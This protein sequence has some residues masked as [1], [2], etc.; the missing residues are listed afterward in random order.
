MRGKK[1]N[2]QKYS[3]SKGRPRATV[4][5]FS[6]VSFGIVLMVDGQRSV[7]ENPRSVFFPYGLLQSVGE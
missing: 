4:L 1:S 5:K 6:A 3:K 7:V 2:I